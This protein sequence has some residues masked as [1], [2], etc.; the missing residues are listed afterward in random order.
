MVIYELSLNVVF[1]FLSQIIMKYLIYL[2]I[3]NISHSSQSLNIRQW[4]KPTT[5][6]KWA[7]KPDKHSDGPLIFPKL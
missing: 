5:F 6:G 1:L 2:L 7:Q 4:R 3:R